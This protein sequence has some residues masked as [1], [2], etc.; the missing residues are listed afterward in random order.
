MTEAVWLLV[1][2]KFSLNFIIQLSLWPWINK[3]QVSHYEFILDGWSQVCGAFFPPLQYPK[4]IQL[5]V[6]LKYFL[7][8]ATL[9]IALKIDCEDEKKQPRRT[10]ASQTHT[11]S[12]VI[13]KYA[14]IYDYK[15]Y[16]SIGWETSLFT[17]KKS[18]W[19]RFSFL[20]ATSKHLFP[21]VPDF[22]VCF[23]EYKGRRRQEGPT[24]MVEASSHQHSLC[25]ESSPVPN[26][27]RPGATL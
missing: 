27:L 11:R 24:V 23:L 13:I 20:V 25:I 9:V 3:L 1:H 18:S 17:D 12:G 21:F 26:H 5:K 22:I 16:Y 4:N 19:W 15:M 6:Y 14:Q 2:L 7:Q 10:S 8:Q